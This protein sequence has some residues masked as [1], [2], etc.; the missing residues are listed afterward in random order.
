[1]QIV[2]IIMKGMTTIMT[3]RELVYK[4]LEFKNETNNVPRH[5]WVLPW[6]A[7]TYPNELAEIKNDFPDDILQGPYTTYS[8]TVETYGIPCEIG[9]YSDEW[10]CKYVNIQRGI[11][12]EVKEPLIDP[13]DEDWEDTG[14]VHIPEEALSF[15]IELVN[16]SCKET[17][18][19]VIA[20]ACPNPFERLQY[21]RGTEQL[22][23]DLMLKPQG[24]LDFIAKMH[25]FY[26]RLMEKW[27]KTDVDALLFM[28]DWGSQNSLLINPTVWVD[29]FKPMYKDYI[30]I[31]H[32]HGKKIFMH[33]DGNT[34]EIFPHLIEMGLDAINSQIFCIG[35]DKLEQ[36][37]GK[38]TFWGE[39][40][41]Q[42]LLPNGTVKDIDDAVKYVREKLWSNGGCIAQCEFGPG[43][44]P[45]N[46]YEIFK[47]WK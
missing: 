12:G 45:L 38:I 2:I 9:E 17:D 15:D 10:G 19:F 27:A 35:I 39:I 34:L 32:K 42:H 16:K 13:E 33:S 20:G 31:A 22:Y 37:K 29:I 47:A 41:R 44:K 23:I 36:Y 25:D 26:K 1:M 11:A 24:M 8:E 7:N 21:I 28:D 3:S 46:V 6:A 5:L 30:D 4:T 18:K 40:D 14:R 43:A